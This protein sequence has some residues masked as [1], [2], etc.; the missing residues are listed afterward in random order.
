LITALKG[1]DANIAEESLRQSTSF[2][3]DDLL[4]LQAGM[5]TDLFFHEYS[6]SSL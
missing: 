6:Q 4:S 2:A 3:R 1:Y 5:P